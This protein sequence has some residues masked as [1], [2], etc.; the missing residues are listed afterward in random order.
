MWQNIGT[1][2][3][4]VGCVRSARINGRHVDLTW[5]GSAHVVRA[6]H[7]TE[8]RASPCAALPCENGGR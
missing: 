8:C 2:E 5:P 1:S 6:E 4:L 7:V 3:G